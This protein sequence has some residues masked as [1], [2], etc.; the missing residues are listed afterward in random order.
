MLLSI[1]LADTLKQITFGV[2]MK[3][4]LL[5]SLCFYLSVSFSF[6]EESLEENKQD[7]LF[8]R[9]TIHSLLEGVYDGDLTLKELRSHGN[10]GIGTYNAL[11][12]EMIFLN[13]VFYRI[14]SNGKAY[15]PSL[16]EQ[17]PFA[18]VTFFSPNSSFVLAL[19]L[20]YAELKT[21]IDSMLP[22]T[23]LPYAIKITGS[24]DYVKTRS[25]PAQVKPYQPLLEIVK[26]QPVFEHKNIKG[27]L[28]GFRL[29]ED[30]KGLNVTGFHLHFIDNKYSYGGHLLEC[31]IKKVKI[32]I[33]ETP[34]VFLSLPT[35]TAFLSSNLDNFSSGA[36][37][38]V[39][40]N[41]NE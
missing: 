41:N 7:I 13:N 15:Q 33:D 14:K 1:A 38:K 6:A 9:A 4:V 5:F 8:Q 23:N 32:E 26:T 29:P 21:H 2:C 28:V 10:F 31:S 37:N 35:D 17:T 25:V 19:P 34:D 40:K 16:E 22:S 39:E 30:F 20:K 12:G 24:F 18:S 36:I 3:K 11:D 27:T